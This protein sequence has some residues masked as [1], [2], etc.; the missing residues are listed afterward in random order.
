[1]VRHLRH[2]A[3]GQGSDLAVQ[4]GSRRRGD[5]DQV[6]EQDLI[7]RDAAVVEPFGR[8]PDF[9]FVRTE[10]REDSVKFRFGLDV[11]PAVVGH[12][13]HAVFVL[14]P[15]DRGTGARFAHPQHQ[16]AAFLIL[17]NPGDEGPCRRLRGPVAGP[18][19]RR[20]L[21]CSPSAP[22]RLGCLGGPA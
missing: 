16:G 7:D 17:L 11:A 5:I 8:E 19:G 20:V 14:P 4:I 6:T 2:R 3:A 9:A 22:R 15:C 18:H 13:L 21:P 1:M 12:P 10:R